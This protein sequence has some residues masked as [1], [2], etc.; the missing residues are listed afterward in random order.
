MRFLS[1]IILSYA[2]ACQPLE[3]KKD[4]SQIT[5]NQEVMKKNLPYDF[6]GATK[7]KLDK[8]LKE[9]SGISF[10]DDKHLVCVQDERALLYTIVLPTGEIVDEKKFGKLGDFEDLAVVGKQVYVLRSDGTIF[11][12][13]NTKE[14]TKVE[15]FDTALSPSNDA[16]GLCYYPASNSLLIVCKENAYINSKVFDNQRAIYRFDL[17]TKQLMEEPFLLIDLSKL[18]AN[19]GYADNF[20]FKPSGIAIHPK[21]SDIYLIASAGKKLLVYDKNF[22][23]KYFESL[24][25][26]KFRQPEGICFDQAGNLYISNEG[27]HK[28]ANILMIKSLAD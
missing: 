19:F 10:T 7:I 11:S 6:A 5:E 23:L 28:K 17:E 26:K 24:D 3:D 2:L 8:K 9:I 25:K 20:E 21:N 15:V 4:N 12:F 22:A 13:E 16:E 18:A 14:N 1:L 27:R